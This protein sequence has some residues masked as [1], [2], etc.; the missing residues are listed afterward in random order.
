MCFGALTR[1][2]ELDLRS[3]FIEFGRTCA[4]ITHEGTPCWSE[5]KPATGVCGGCRA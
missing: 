2:Q 4:G 5:R 3:V 1:K